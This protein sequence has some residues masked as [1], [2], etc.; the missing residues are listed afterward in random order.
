MPDLRQQL[1]DLEDQCI[2]MKDFAI[3]TPEECSSK[4]RP[5]CPSFTFKTPTTYRECVSLVDRIAMEKGIDMSI[6]GVFTFWRSVRLIILITGISLCCIPCCMRLKNNKF[7]RQLGFF[8]LVC[9]IIWIR[10]T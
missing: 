7:L 4:I 2:K 9:V 3:L 8:M 6:L 1:L 5:I 10:N